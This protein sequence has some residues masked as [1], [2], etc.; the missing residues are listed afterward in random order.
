[1]KI[2]QLDIEGVVHCQGLPVRVWC[3]AI[4]S[5]NIIGH[6]G[7]AFLRFLT[8]IIMRSLGARIGIL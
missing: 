8:T 6:Q 2:K 4:A 3:N 7:K 5:S 1:M